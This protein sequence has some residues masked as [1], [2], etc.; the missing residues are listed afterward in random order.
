[1]FPFILCSPHIAQQAILLREARE[2][3]PRQAWQQ[4]I[5]ESIQVLQAQK[6]EV[7][8]AGDFNTAKITRRVIK[9]LFTQCNLEIIS[10]SS[11]ASLH[12]NREGYA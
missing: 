5:I 10:H 4:D 11:T 9:E 12:I 8:I 7:V 6:V 3:T 1:M 2:V